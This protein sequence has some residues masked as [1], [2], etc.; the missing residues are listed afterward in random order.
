MVRSPFR[1]LW[2]SAVFLFQGA[3]AESASR[4]SV[5]VDAGSTGCRVFVYEIGERDGETTVLNSVKGPKA[6][7]GLAALAAMLDGP[8][9]VRDAALA[10]YVRPLLFHAVEHVPKR[11]WERTPFSV[12]AT[13]GMRLLPDETSKALYDALHAVLQKGKSQR[14]GHFL[15]A[16]GASNG[17]EHR[18]KNSLGGND[19]LCPFAVSRRDVRTISGDDE[20]FYAA[21]T[22]NFVLGNIDARR[23]PLARGAAQNGGAWLVGALDLGGASTQIASPASAETP[24]L[25][26]ALERK[27]FETSSYLGFGVER[28]AETYRAYIDSQ[29]VHADPCDTPGRERIVTAPHDGDANP[30]VVRG[31]GDYDECIT[32]VAKAVGL[33]PCRLRTNSTTKSSLLKRDKCDFK[34]KDGSTLAALRPL[35]HAR[36][37]GLSLYYYAWRTLSLAL[38]RL[39]DDEKRRRRS[40]L[41]EIGELAKMPAAHVSRRAA[42]ALLATWPSPSLRTVHAAA[43]VFCATPWATLEL[44]A[45]S[46]ARSWDAFMGDADRRAVEFPRRCMDLAYI[47]LLLGDVYRIDS[48]E[49]ALLVAVEM[50]G[51]ELD[52]TLGAVLD[53]VDDGAPPPPPPPRLFSTV[54]AFSF[55][56]V[57]VLCFLY[58]V[59]RQVRRLL[60]RRVVRSPREAEKTGS[61][62][63][64]ESYKSLGRP[65]SF[66]SLSK[67]MIRG[68]QSSKS[69]H[70]QLSH[71]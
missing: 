22:A 28:V 71:F 23:R 26:R 9:E 17:P 59:V 1:A 55:A 2:L 21:L 4:F 25:S 66:E 24:G 30:R 14:K 58:C 20:A 10:A 5:V 51:V 31:T 34:S 64:R 44:V 54:V 36:F 60:R 27:D 63:M 3:R 53:G 68:P 56:V 33:E 13:A 61:P 62:Q 39:V 6:S 38:G 65:P 18:R 37:V 45:T 42:E 19:I 15:R 8:A 57:I 70:S 29:G 41:L 7:P 40:Q 46:P 48:D 43:K 11:E 16:Q 49:R 12:L 35:P 67:A 47:E 50:N 69:Y 52:W 32:M